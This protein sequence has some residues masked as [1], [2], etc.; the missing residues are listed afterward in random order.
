MHPTRP[1][2]QLLLLDLRLLARSKIFYFK[3]VLLPLALVCIIG[4]LIG[5]G[6]GQEAA[7]VQ[8]PQPPASFAAVLNMEQ[9]A[10]HAGPL[11]AV[12]YESVAM[13]VMFSILTAFELA[14][15]IVDDR[16]KGALGRIR[17]S[18]LPAWQY[19]F[20]KLLGIT[21]AVCVQM[22]VVMAGT[23]LLFGV[24]WSHVPG[25]LLVTLAYGLAIGSIVLCCG[26]AAGSHS[27]ISSMSTPI[28]YGFSFLGGSFVSKY[29]LP[30]GLRRIQELLPNGKAL[31][32]YLALL[33]GGGFR[34]IRGEVLE[35]SAL[36]LAFF[37]AALFILQKQGGHIHAA[38]ANDRQANQADV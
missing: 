9:V 15:S 4:S 27:T 5:G 20:G 26:L 28:L 21:L 36:A 13:A 6:S 12:Q 25:V 33:R 24:H 17:S 7:P 14:H 32:G 11:N 29:S 31:N 23:R 35:L 16:L 19:G 3:L 1:L 37:A 2:G 38:A 30:D 10:V 34:D 8:P 22:T 18:P